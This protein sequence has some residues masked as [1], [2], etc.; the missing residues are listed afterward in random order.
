MTAQIKTLF[1]LKLYPLYFFKGTKYLIR[2]K[3]FSSFENT[4]EPE[5]HL[6]QLL[7]R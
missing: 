4:W 6:S 3:G 1:K 7:L 5:Q 2:W